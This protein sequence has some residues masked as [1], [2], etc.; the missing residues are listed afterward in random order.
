M[1]DAKFWVAFSFVVLLVLLTKPLRRAINQAL[2]SRS[3]QIQ[4]ELDEAVRLKEEAESILVSYKRKQKEVLEEAQHI[5]EHAEQEVA[6]ISREAHE[7]LESELNRR[8]ALAVQKIES[9]EA[10]TLQEV[11][12]QAVDTA[13]TAIRSLAAEHM[14]K[15]TAD[16]LVDN[17]INDISKSVH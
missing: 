16:T 14:D 2:D 11:R 1:F 9:Y 3:V 8:K 12:N 7:T 4:K 15:T 5:L 6:R 10:R 13:I 17:A